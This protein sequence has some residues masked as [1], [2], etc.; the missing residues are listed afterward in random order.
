MCS[1][2]VIIPPFGKITEIIPNPLRRGE[3]S[4]IMYKTAV[5]FGGFLKKQGGLL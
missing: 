5:L 4:G 1:F 2:F 3:E